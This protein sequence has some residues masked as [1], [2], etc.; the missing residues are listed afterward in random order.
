MVSLTSGWS[1][2][3]DLAGQIFG[4]GD[5]I[6]ENGSQQIVGAHALDGRRNLAAAAE[7]QDRQ[8]ARGIPAP[9]RGE[10]RRIQQG[11]RQH[12]FDGLRLQELEDQFERKGVLLGERDVD[13][14]VGG[15]GLQLEIERTAEALAQ[16]E[17]PGP[18]DARAE[19][20]VQDELHAAG[21]IEE[22]FG[23]H[24]VAAWAGH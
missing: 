14:V 20:G 22:S 15:G 16:R 6:R 7:A 8:R 21:F 4:A 5:L 11:L 12:V 17:T 23:D 9:A 24:G 2:I 1:G 18:I 19:R 10:H 13:A 3:S